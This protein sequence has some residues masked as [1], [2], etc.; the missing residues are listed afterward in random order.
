MSPQQPAMT[1]RI[2]RAISSKPARQTLSSGRRLRQLSLCV[3]LME[4]RQLLTLPAVLTIPL[5]PDLDQFGDQVLV[6]QAFGVPERAALGIF[7]SGASAVTFAAQDQDFFAMVDVGPIPIKVVGGALAEGIGGVIIGDV[8]ESGTIYSDGMHSFDLTFDDMGFPQFNIALSDTA[9][10]TPNIQAFVGTDNSPLLP[11]ITGTPALNPSPKYPDGAAAHV[12]MQGAM[13][14]FSDIFPGLVIPFPDLTFANP[15]DTIV[16]DSSNIDIYE[17]VYLPLIPF[18]ADN[19]SDPGDLITESLLWLIPNI[20]STYG[21]MTSGKGNFLFDTGAQLSVISTDMALSLGLDLGNPTTSIDVQGVAGA[22]T[23]SGFTLKTLEIQRSDGGILEFTDVPVYVLDVAPGIDGIFG[24]NLLNVANEFVF[25]PKSPTGPQLSIAYFANPDRGAPADDSG[26]GD[27][28]ALFKLVG[29]NALGGALGGT[30]SVP[31]FDLPKIGTTTSLNVTNTSVEFGGNWSLNAAVGFPAGSTVPTGTM[32]FQKNGVAFASPGLDAQGKASWSSSGTPWEPGT[33]QIASSYSGDQKYGSSVSTSTTIEIHKTASSLTLAGKGVDYGQAISLTGKMTTG[34]GVSVLNSSIELKIDGVVFGHTTAAADGSYG[35]SVSGL[36]AGSHS[37]IAT[38]AESSH[39]KGSSSSTSTIEVSKLSSSLTLAGTG[40][41]YGQAI[42]LTGKMTTGSGVSV[43]N[44]SI[45]LKVDGVVFGNTTAAA[46]GSYG[47][48]VSGL[49]A[50]SHS[51]IAT[52]SGSNNFKAASSAVVN[53]QV[54]KASTSLILMAS[55]TQIKTGQS[56][57]LSGQLSSNTNAKFVD[58]S[59]QMK[60]DGALS[61]IAT[62][63]AADGSYTMSLTNLGVG[64]HTIQMVFAEASNFKGSSSAMVSVVVSKAAGV[65]V[66]VAPTAAVFGQKVALVAQVGQDQAV[67][68]ENATV[69]FYDDKTILGTS[70]MQSGKAT[71]NYT[72]SKAGLTLHLLAKLAETTMGIA[73][74]SPMAMVSTS[75]ASTNLAWT[76][77]K[78]PGNVQEWTITVSPA[79]PGTGKPSGTLKLTIGG[80]K[81]TTKTLKL[82]AGKTVY[83]FSTTATKPK[84]ITFTGDTNFLGS[85]RAV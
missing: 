55:G 18:G 54:A 29:L 35:F 9:I 45:E 41:D 8:S 5:I 57:V 30:R 80:A 58:S 67:A 17:T 84:S 6:V 76:I 25:D 38:F 23:V 28:A 53:A 61:P 13:L 79:S 32:N 63:A 24:M 83:K 49:G 47:F 42:S 11:T 72:V 59:V 71:W 81:P 22:E 62:R 65:L 7:D 43:L 82:A 75:K 70:K 51:F 15:G 3:E 48:S 36:G 56:L 52:F 14:D 1:S 4:S 78:K 12:K 34:S 2:F 40:V 16:Y 69:T 19:S 46:D 39:V 31:R 74:S 68:Y 85:S 44:S 73:V 60:L 10:A 64:L 20:T 77:V 26:M 50:G 37:F 33:Y 66:V 27:L 21:D